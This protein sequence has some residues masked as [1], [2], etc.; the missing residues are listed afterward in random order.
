MPLLSGFDIL[1]R[2]NGL[3]PRFSDI[4][5]IFLTALGDRASELK[6]RQLGA[7]DYISKPIDFDILEAIVRKRLMR[8]G[9][10]A[11]EPLADC[12]LNERE[13]E[14]LTWSARGKTS[15][16]IASILGISK[17][18]VDFH[19]DNARLKLGV[20]TRIQAAVKATVH[21]LIEP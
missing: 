5:F 6:G 19:I 11:A 15:D 21:R 12:D 8:A 7:D 16:E 10:T 13:I 14:T 1:E 9:Q 4:P 2:L 3:A 17:R 18:T 20:T